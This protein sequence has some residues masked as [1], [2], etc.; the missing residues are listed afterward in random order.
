MRRVF[1]FGL[2]PLFGVLAAYGQSRPHD[3]QPV[4]ISNCLRQAPNG[5]A[6]VVRDSAA[7]V[8]NPVSELKNHQLGRPVVF[9][10]W[11]ISGY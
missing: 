2:L 7:F 6:W 10:K 11:K 8:L 5:I 1:L 4:L 9:K 3:E